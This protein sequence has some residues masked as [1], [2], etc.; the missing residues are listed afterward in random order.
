MHKKECCKENGRCRC[1]VW[2][3]IGWGVLGV[4]GFAVI[5]A[6]LGLAI[7]LL[8]NRLIPGIFNL[9]MISYC[10]AIGLAVLSRLLFGGCGM[11]FRHF[12]HR[13]HGHKCGCG[14]SKESDNECCSD[15]GKEG[16]YV[17]K[18]EAP[19]A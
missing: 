15:K 18:E 1:S 6:L 2:R 14:C 16:E 9:P 8:W 13:H 19:Q 11:G 3:C 10:E 12:R 5:V 4:V 17:H 7:M